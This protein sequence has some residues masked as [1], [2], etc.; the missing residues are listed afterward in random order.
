MYPCRRQIPK[1]YPVSHSLVA[2]H[3]L[4]EMVS[5]GYELARNTFKLL[6]KQ[7]CNQ[8]GFCVT[9]LGLSSLEQ[10]RD[11]LQHSPTLKMIQKVT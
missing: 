8:Y 3:K 9:I 11:L 5:L 2:I 1:L 4:M 6:A 10:R 7:Y